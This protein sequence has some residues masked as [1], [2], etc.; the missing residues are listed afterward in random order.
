MRQ[1]QIALERGDIGRRDLDRGEFA[2][3]G[4]DAVD[5]LVAGG[6]FRNARGCLFD[7]GV[8]RRGRDG[9][10]TFAAPVDLR[11]FCE[12]TRPG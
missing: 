4:I 2:E 11:K 12:G 3:A 6:D 5:R 9:W 7:A 10:S 1:D 8:E